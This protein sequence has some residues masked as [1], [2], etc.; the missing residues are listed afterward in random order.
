MFQRSERKPVSPS[1]K[2]EGFS[3]REAVA[4]FQAGKVRSLEEGD[5][6]IRTGEAPKAIMFALHGTFKIVREGIPGSLL[7]TF[8]HQGNCF[9]D[10]DFSG[11]MQQAFSVI[12]V[13]ASKVLELDK[14]SFNLLSSDIQ[15]AVCRKIITTSA[16]VIDKIGSLS[17]GLTRK[18]QSLVSLAKTF[19][20]DDE[21]YPRSVLV[22]D[23]I[24]SFPRLPI[25]INKLTSMLLDEGAAVSEIVNFAKM[26]PSIVSI[27]LK[28]VNSGFYNF[29]RK[30]S[31]LHHAFVLLGF[32]QVY[33][34]LMDNFLQ[35]FMPKHFNLKELNLHS[36]VISQIAFDLSQVSKKGRPVMMSTLGILHDLGKCVVLVS[37]GRRPELDIVLD[38]MNDGQI[39]AL[40]L[41]TWNTPAVMCKS[42]E[43]QYYPQFC[44]PEDIPKDV[45]E[46][47]AIL[48]VAHLC[49]NHLRGDKT[50][51]PPYA[52][53]EEY[54]RV[55]DFG[56]YSIESLVSRHILPSLTRKIDVFPDYVRD[57]IKSCQISIQAG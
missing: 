25:Q 4:L 56:G 50:E 41:D 22:Q 36:A 43:Y 14:L 37:K 19:Y 21:R 39:G 46:N 44:P 40:L 17:A 8:G 13:S 31:D 1:A 53:T 11:N 29:Q 2:I 47:V 18:V 24:K 26:D 20:R 32:N 57:F 23:M 45:M 28:T 33:Q 35:G 10:P 9:G 15:M 7:L 3:E 51:H 42:I 49:Y 54:M 16:M 27:V 30:I 48:H 52:F 6:V 12:S 34:I 55:L 38:K 5:Y